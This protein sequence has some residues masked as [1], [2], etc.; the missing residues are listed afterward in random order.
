MATLEP[1]ATA[2]AEIESQLHVLQGELDEIETRR[3]EIISEKEELEDQ[4]DRLISAF[5]ALADSRHS[6]DVESPAAQ[7]PEEV[8]PEAEVESASPPAEKNS[9]SSS[10][11]TRGRPNAMVDAMRQVMSDRTMTSTEVAEALDEAGLAPDSKNLVAYVS[12]VLSSATDDDGEKIFV[13]PSRGL[14]CVAALQTEDQVSTP[15]VEVE[16]EPES[17]E[18]EAETATT[19][20]AEKLLREV[21]LDSASLG[22]PA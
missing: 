3:N 14:Y 9:T 15:S 21:G 6:E 11:R 20:P 16:E 18:K 19:S 4:L 5:P 17:V 2:K 10:R 7:S 12:S 8:T 13:R 1:L 22:V